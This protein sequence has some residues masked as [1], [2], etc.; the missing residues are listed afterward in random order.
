MNFKLFGDKW[1]QYYKRG[2]L[3][4]FFIISFM[5]VIDQILNT[6]LFFSKINNL[7]ILLFTI[8]T[9]FFASVFCGLLGMI[10]LL[11]VSLVSKK[12]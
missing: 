10:Y 1:T 5:C 11:F 7:S 2:F 6:P 4:S 12:N 8:S 3:V 9:I